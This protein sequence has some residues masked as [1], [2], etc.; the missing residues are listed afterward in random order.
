MEKSHRI[1][2]AG[3]LCFRQQNSNSYLSLGYLSF[4]FPNSKLSLLSLGQD[5]IK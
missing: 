1:A 4:I 5:S 3:P 2:W